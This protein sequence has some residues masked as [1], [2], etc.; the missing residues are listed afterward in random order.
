V[1]ITPDRL[2]QDCVV[3][4]T[5]KVSFDAAAFQHHARRAALE[6]KIRQRVNARGAGAGGKT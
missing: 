2:F 1:E 3:A 5:A 4:R 6:Q